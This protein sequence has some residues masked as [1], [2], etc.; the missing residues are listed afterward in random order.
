[1]VRQGVVKSAANVDQAWIGTNASELLE[2]RL[3]R[4]VVVLNDADAAGL[5]EVTFGA[6]R[7]RA[8]VLVMVTFG[9]GIGT[10]LFSMDDSFRA[11]SWATSSSPVRTANVWLP[12]A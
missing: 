4:P 8:G 10:A 2:A 7:G 11:P 9:T 6:G 3:G 1:M 5:A 12:P